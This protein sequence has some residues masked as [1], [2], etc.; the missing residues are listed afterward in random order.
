[1]IRVDKLQKTYR[2]PEKDPGLMG[3][4]RSLFDRRWIDRHALAPI[5]FEVAPG[6]II[7]LLGANGAGKTTLIKMLA[8]IMHPTAGTADVQGFVPWERK[9]A[10]KRQIAIVLGQKS[11]LWPDLPAADS[12]LLLREIYGLEQGA[13]QKRL[14]FFLDTLDLRKLLKTQIRRLSLGE[15]MKFELVAALIHEPKVIFLDEPTIGLDIG[16]Q[17]AIR[18]FLSDYR[19]TFKPA[20]ILTSH[21]ME[22]V[23]A[24]CERLLILREGELVYEGKLSNI[25]ESYANGRN[26]RLQLKDDSVK[27]LLLEKFPAMKEDAEQSGLMRLHINKDQVSETLLGIL[28]VAPVTDLAV[29]EEDLGN[30]IDSLQTRR[31][32]GK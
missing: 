24:L 22:D 13:Y 25:S 5:S 19:R 26:I 1:M 4:V 6:E 14:D 31:G 3:S 20:M 17:R 27:K 30:I 15:R 8:G 23:E 18:T 9:N 7:G 32:A 2:I 16:S 29:E 28:N 10:F 21:Y 12:L 11:Q